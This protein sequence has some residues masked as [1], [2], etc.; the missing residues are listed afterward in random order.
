VDGVNY[1]TTKLTIAEYLDKIF[2][3]AALGEDRE[4]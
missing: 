3:S 1:W 2:I 4:E